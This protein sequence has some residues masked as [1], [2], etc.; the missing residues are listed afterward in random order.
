MFWESEGSL[1]LRHYSGGTWAPVETVLQGNSLNKGYYPNLKLGTSGE[2]LE[3]VFTHCSG[4]PFRLVV[5]GQPVT[6]GP[7]PP[8]LIYLPIVLNHKP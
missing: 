7:T 3:W 1:L 2:R 5:D 4:A 8:G 6:P